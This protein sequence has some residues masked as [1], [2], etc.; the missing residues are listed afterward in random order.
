ML[1]ELSW[2]PAAPENFRQ[3][4]RALKQSASA[5]PSWP[6]IWD[7]L[8][9]LAAFALDEV[10][11][12]QLRNILAGLPDHPGLPSR[13]K[14]GILGA[15]D[16]TLSFLGPAIAASAIRRD[17]RVEVVEADYG[18]AMNEAMDPGSTAG[19]HGSSP[20]TTTWARARV[21]PAPKAAPARRCQE[22][23]GR[24]R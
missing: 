11:L 3:L 5:S 7:Q 21:L 14:L 13:L 19:V 4:A 24:T 6:D 9:R 2:L 16:G 1:Q 15:G 22:G 23:E 20:W 12:S 18:T 10:Q 8:K 17:L